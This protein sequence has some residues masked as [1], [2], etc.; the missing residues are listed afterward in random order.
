MVFVKDV[1]F[2]VVG[3][4]L[5]FFLVSFLQLVPSFTIVVRIIKRVFE[6]TSQEH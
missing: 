6:I 4:L 2:F 3:L 1:Y 5:S